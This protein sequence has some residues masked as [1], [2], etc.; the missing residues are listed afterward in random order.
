MTAEGCCSE[1]PVPHRQENALGQAS[2]AA[3][4]TDHRVVG[5][6]EDG[7]ASHLM[8]IQLSSD[9]TENIGSPERDVIIYKDDLVPA[10]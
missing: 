3:R 9:A 5:I 7:Y 4:V 1:R 8:S 2:E 10:I 6:L